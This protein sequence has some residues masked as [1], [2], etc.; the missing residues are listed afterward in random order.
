MD[1]FNTTLHKKYKAKEQSSLPWAWASETSTR[2]KRP[3]S[4][5]KLVKRIFFC[6]VKVGVAS[7]S[8]D[9]S[10]VSLSRRD[11]YIKV[12]AQHILHIRQRL[13]AS[14][15]VRVCARNKQISWYKYIDICSV[16]MYLCIHTNLAWCREF[17]YHSTTVYPHYYKAYH[18]SVPQANTN[19]TG[20][21]YW[22]TN[23]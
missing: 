4:N 19:I 2:R 16:D 3:K 15:K 12:R 1:S 6:Y 17:H 18:L 23:R 14:T 10:M 22:I 20:I 7:V 13:R 21:H 8:R 5:N 9:D 11:H